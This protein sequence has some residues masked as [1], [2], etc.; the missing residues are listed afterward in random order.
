VT[1]PVPPVELPD[2]LKEDARRTNR[3]SVVYE[4]QP[5][6]PT[7]KK[8]KLSRADKLIL[9]VTT[10]ILTFGST[11]LWAILMNGQHKL[12]L[13]RIHLYTPGGEQ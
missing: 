7:P 6:A 5:T 3:A 10:A 4:S 11:Y 12:P 2:F 13:L 1:S 9:V 8:N